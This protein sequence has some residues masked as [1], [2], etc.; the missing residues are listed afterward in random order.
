VFR[1]M[2]G[3][4]I[5]IIVLAIIILIGWKRLPDAARSLG[6][7]MRI[8]KSEVEQMGS[9]PEKDQPSA[10]SSDTVDSETSRRPSPDHEDGKADRPRDEQDAAEPDHRP[11]D[12]YRS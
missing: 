3:W 5:V 7:S 9:S 2:Q 8:F 11:S 6:R 4:Q 10:A 1:N 12:E